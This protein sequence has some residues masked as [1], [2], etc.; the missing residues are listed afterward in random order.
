[1]AVTVAGVADGTHQ[2]LLTEEALGG[3]LGMAHDAT[4]CD[5]PAAR[6]PLG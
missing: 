6:Q 3:Q 1:M 4:G 2:L 5:V